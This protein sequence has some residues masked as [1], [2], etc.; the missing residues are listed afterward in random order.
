M[1]G[2]IEREAAGRGP[3]SVARM[4][5][6]VGLARSTH[7]RLRARRSARVDR[8]P[9]ARRAVRRVAGQMPAYGCRRVTIHLQREGFEVGRERV[10]RLMR[11]EGLTVRPKRRF[12]RTTQSDHG[13]KVWPNL[14]KEFMPTGVNQLWV[15]DLTYI[16]MA[17]GFVYLAAILDAFSRRCIGWSLGQTLEAVLTIEALEM[18]LH[19]RKVEPGLIHHSDRGVQYACGDYVALL[20]E[21]GIAISMSR[22]ACPTDNARAESFMK[23]FKCEEVYLW[24][25]ADAADARRRVGHFIERIYNEKRLHSAIGYWPP[26][27][28]ERRLLEADAA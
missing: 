27:Q 7:Y 17:R 11:E 24:E 15:A 26:A 28:F 18:A 22:R 6:V 9:Q 12:V 23:T 4:C 14:A 19:R 10:R 8:D 13:L 2:L 5:R 21:A 3:G 25:Y 16:A 20:K 1:S